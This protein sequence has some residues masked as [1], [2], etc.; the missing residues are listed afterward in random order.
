MRTFSQKS[1]CS[2]TKIISEYISRFQKRRH[3]VLK[4]LFGSENFQF[5]R[6]LQFLSGTQSQF[7]E[8][9]PLNERGYTFHF[10]ICTHRLWKEPFEAVMCAV[11]AAALIS[12]SLLKTFIWNP[13]YHLNFNRNCMTKSSY[14]LFLRYKYC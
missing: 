14:K 6:M 11:G 4:N 2:P 5:R 9:R 7:E 3:T 1:L 13:K 10:H 12:C 8:T